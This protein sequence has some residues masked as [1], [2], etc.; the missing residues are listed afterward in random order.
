[1]RGRFRTWLWQITSNAVNDFL[2]KRRRIDR[3]EDEKRQQ[4]DEAPTPEPDPEWLAT[5][6]KRL[7]EFAMQQIKGQTAPKTWACFELHLLKGK[8]GAEVAEALELT[9]NTVYVNASRVMARI[10]ELCRSYQ[11]DLDD[12]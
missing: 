1:G 4:F 3:V 6:R 12:A 9:A 8:P 7:P 2:R 11:E 10:R 5:H